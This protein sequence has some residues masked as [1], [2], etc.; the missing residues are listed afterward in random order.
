LVVCDDADLDKAAEAAVLSAF[1][2]AG[3]RCAAGSR[4]IVFDAIYDEFRAR[5]VDRTAGQKVGPGDEQDFGPVINERQL[6]NMLA[7]VQR[8][9]DGGATIVTGG[10]RLDRPGFYLA[11]T[12][13]EDVD[14]GHEISRTELFGPITT[15]H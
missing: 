14:G 1:S 7:A 3:Q 10:E 13:V 5:L 9:R 6:E 11:P 2:N 12:I 8:A 4:L 15:L